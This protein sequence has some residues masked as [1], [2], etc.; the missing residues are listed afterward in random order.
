MRNQGRSQNTNGSLGIRTLVVVLIA[1]LMASGAFLVLRERPAVRWQRVVKE[2]DIATLTAMIQDGS[3]DPSIFFVEEGEANVSAENCVEYT[4][5]TWAI[6]HQRMETVSNLIKAGVD[7]NATDGCGYAPIQLAIKNGNM[8]TLNALLEAGAKVDISTP[9]SDPPVILAV[10][11]QSFAMLGRLALAVPN[12]NCRAR[13]GAMPLALAA[14]LDHNDMVSLLLSQRA[15]ADSTDERGRSALVHAILNSN[16]TMVKEL[17][18]S[19]ADVNQLDGSGR[20]PLLAAIWHEQWEVA[21]L[22]IAQG[23]DISYRKKDDYSPFTLTALRGN[24][25]FLKM[26]IARGA[27]PLERASPHN[28]GALFLAAFGGHAE[29][30]RFLLSEFGAEV[31]AVN[32]FQLT[33]LMEAAKGYRVSGHPAIPVLLEYGAE[34]DWLNEYGESAVLLAVSVGTFESFQT[35]VE[36]GADLGDE[37]NLS[38]L[39]ERAERRNQPHGIRIAEFLKAKL[40]DQ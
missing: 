27:D 15:S 2:G 35:L 34:I 24:L 1:C 11:E 26:L 36:H 20:A 8:K 6:T 4:A 30:C 23:A 37:A 13:D 32:D 39:I 33:P 7:V 16:P 21:D 10:Q 12:M 14:K 18:Q 3:I 9:Q 19:G 22:L 38:S 5:L 17:L 25:E 40:K 31:N 29:I 28:T